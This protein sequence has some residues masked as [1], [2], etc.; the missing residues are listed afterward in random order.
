MSMFRCDISFGRIWPFRS[1]IIDDLGN[2]HFLVTNMCIL[3]INAYTT[4]QTL[5][6]GIKCNIGKLGTTLVHKFALVEKRIV[7]SV[8][9]WQANSLK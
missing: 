6:P 7:I 9:W 4:I 1:Q 3:V 2:Q 5:V 8:R